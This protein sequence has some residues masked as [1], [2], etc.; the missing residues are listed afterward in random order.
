LKVQ[1]I[2]KEEEAAKDILPLAGRESSGHFLALITNGH[3]FQD[4]LAGQRT[5]NVQFV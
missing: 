5:N 2:R 1:I 4:K 3:S